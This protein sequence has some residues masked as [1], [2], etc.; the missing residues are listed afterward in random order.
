MFDQP[1]P[2][3]SG[4]DPVVLRAQRGAS[5]IFVIIMLL[6]VF[7]LVRGYLGGTTTAQ[8]IGAVASM[9]AGALGCAWAAWY[10]T[11]RRST[12]R[13]SASAITLVK[14]VPARHRNDDGHTFILY[15]SSGT[16]LRVLTQ[17]RQGRTYITGLTIPGSGTTL[18]IGGFDF[19]QVKKACVAKGWQ[20]P[21]GRRVATDSVPAGSATQGSA[22]GRDAAPAALRPPGRLSGL[23]IACGV[24]WAVL[25]LG[26]GAGGAGELTIGIPGAAIMCFVFAAGAAWYDIMVWTSRAR[27]LVLIIV[28]VRERPQAARL[29]R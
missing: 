11:F 27:L 18:S 21:G 10:M 1:V 7:A 16:D 12:L 23:R 8:R 3:E 28:Y 13:I 20:F 24:I 19:R 25:A 14:P 22:A 4:D 29:G 15:R 2:S 17:V 9:G 26:M 5:W 6:F